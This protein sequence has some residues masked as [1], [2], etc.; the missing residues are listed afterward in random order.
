MPS[1]RVAPSSPVEAVYNAVA[2][3]MRKS[4]IPSG[5]R[6]PLLVI[7]SFSLSS[8]LFSIAAEI[9]AGDLAAIS[10]HTESWAEIT[11]LLGWKV[12]QLAVCWFGGFDAYDTVALALLMSTPHNLLLSL[13]YSIRPTTILFTSIAN[14]LSVTAPFMLLRQVS[15]THAPHSAPRGTVRNRAILTDP[16]TTIATSLLATAIFSVLLELSFATFLP[17]HLITHF[18]GVRDLTAAHLGA[19]GLPSLLVAL[20]PTGYAAREFI[21]VSSTGVP[22]SPEKDTFDPVTSGLREHIYH[23]AWGW[24]SPRQKELISRTGLLAVMV[25]GETIIQTWGTIRGVEFTGAAL[26]AAIWTAGIAVVGDRKSVV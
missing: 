25:L 16:W 8:L 23:N 4:Q 20:L 9:T 11:G 2:D 22:A 21:F 19:A 5:L 10:K 26:Y 15:P 13:F 6:F 1:Q 17:V 12:V 18:T 14:I 3:P 7:L 24:Y